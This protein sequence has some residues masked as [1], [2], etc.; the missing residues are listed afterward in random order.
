[1]QRS[2]SNSI[3]CK[4]FCDCCMYRICTDQLYYCTKHC[5]Q[6]WIPPEC[7]EYCTDL[8]VRRGIRTVR[9]A[10]GEPVL[11]RKQYS[12]IVQQY[13]SVQYSQIQYISTAVY[14][15]VRYS[16]VVQECTVQLDTVQQYSSVQYSQIQ[17][18]STHLSIKL[19]IC[20]IRL[21]VFINHCLFYS[22]KWLPSSQTVLSPH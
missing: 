3:G 6:R 12:Q 20:Y 17:Y 7:T 16:T 15:T 4:H 22:T 19:S 14:S 18:S 10:A 11:S 5:V 9:T 13:S 8:S 2:S 1:M 21:T